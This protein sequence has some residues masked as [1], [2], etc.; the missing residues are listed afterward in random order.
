VRRRRN[1]V[2]NGDSYSVAFSNAS[3]LQ[4]CSGEP[5]GPLASS[6][7]LADAGDP[8]SCTNSGN[9]LVRRLPAFAA[10]QETSIVQTRKLLLASG[11]EALMFEPVSARGSLDRM[12]NQTVD[13][14][15][16]AVRVVAVL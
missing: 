4:Y 8:G 16:E 6:R 5:R 2:A 9:Q 7:G 14:R 3:G 12:V 15:E 13:L 1:S 11:E 10:R